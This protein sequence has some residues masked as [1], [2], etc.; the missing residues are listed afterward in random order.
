MVGDCL[1]VIVYL[2]FYRFIALFEL[3]FK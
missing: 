3:E 2:V 1:L